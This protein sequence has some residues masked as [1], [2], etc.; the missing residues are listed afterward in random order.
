MHILEALAKI[1]EEE[2]ERQQKLA[3]DHELEMYRLNSK[4]QLNDAIKEAGEAA[5]A[6]GQSKAFECAAKVIRE[7]VISE[8][9]NDELPDNIYYALNCI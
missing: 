7:V 8:E 5:Q 9:W 3:D 1:F 4:L 2:A 6:I